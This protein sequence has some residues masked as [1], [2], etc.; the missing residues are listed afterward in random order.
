MKLQKADRLPRARPGDGGKNRKVLQEQG[1]GR[2]SDPQSTQLL[3]AKGRTD[4]SFF[5][6]QKWAMT[7]LS[8]PVLK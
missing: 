4:E 7:Y 6:A 3:G 8:D 5:E 2:P 1:R